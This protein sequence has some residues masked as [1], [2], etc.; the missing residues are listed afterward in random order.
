MIFTSSDIPLE[1]LYSEIP[2]D[3]DTFISDPKYIGRSTMNGEAIYPFWKEK[4][5]YIFNTPD[6]YKKPMDMIVLNTA[7]AV[8]KTR[9]SVLGMLYFMYNFMCLRDP[10]SHFKLDTECKVSIIFASN[11]LE[12]AEGVAY[13]TFLQYISE[14]PW[15][16]E[17]GKV[18]LNRK[19][20]TVSGYIPD[21]PITIITVSSPKHILGTNPIGAYIDRVRNMGDYSV[22]DSMMSKVRER[23]RSRFTMNG[24]N[25][26]KIFVDNDIYFDDTMLDPKYDGMVIDPMYG[27]MWYNIRGALWDIKPSETFSEETIPIVVNPVLGKSRV[28]WDKN[29]VPALKENEH[30]IEVPINFE[31]SI[32]L[33]ENN[34]IEFARFILIQLAGEYVTIYERNVSFKDAMDA[35]LNKEMAIR[36]EGHKQSY[37]VDNGNVV[38][39]SYRKIDI[40]NVMLFSDFVSCNDWVVYPSSFVRIK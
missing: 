22:V 17:H 39:N 11:T 12:N 27:G 25:Y 29:V 9:F 10:L 15:F 1:E 28:I 40:S 4:L 34:P 8:G 37:F 13:R 7:I 23:C 18:K 6:S 20:C 19:Y 3:V 32:K 30:I 33:F 31:Q 26:S 24:I 5:N 21:A 38:D 16:C 36:M 14:S 2:V 35:M